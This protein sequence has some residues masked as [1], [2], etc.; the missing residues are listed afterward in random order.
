MKRD[1]KDPMPMAQNSARDGGGNDP[2]KGGEKHNQSKGEKISASSR[3]PLMNPMSPEQPTRCAGDG[4]TAVSQVI[5][6]HDSKKAEKISGS[7]ERWK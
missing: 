5:E 1:N 7:T 6:K 4:N 3:L 2:T